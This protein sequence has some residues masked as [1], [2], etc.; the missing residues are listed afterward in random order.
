[1]NRPD[2]YWRTQHDFDT[3][4][5]DIVSGGGADWSPPSQAPRGLP[6]AAAPRTPLTKLVCSVCGRF[7]ETPDPKAVAWCEHRGRADNCKPSLM[8]RVERGV[9]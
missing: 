6:S 7:V 1:M 9:A 2:L 3:R 8:K 5:V 4:F